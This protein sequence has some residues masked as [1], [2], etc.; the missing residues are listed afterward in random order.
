[1]ILVVPSLEV[2]E[3]RINQNDDCYDVIY[4]V[5]SFCSFLLTHVSLTL[6][7]EHPLVGAVA[8]E[9]Q[10]EEVEKC[11]AATSTQSD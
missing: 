3:M 2:R 9:E 8:Y 6:A 4:T 5:S 1:M 10:R 11:V 7:P